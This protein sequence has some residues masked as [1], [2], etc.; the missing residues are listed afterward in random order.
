MHWFLTLT[1][2]RQ[3]I[4]TWRREYN[5]SRPHRA[6]GDRTPSEFAGQIA[7]QGDLTGSQTCRRADVTCGPPRPP[8]RRPG[9]TGSTRP[10]QQSH[11]KNLRK[12]HAY[13]PGEICR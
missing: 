4:E 11:E 7:V 3:R 2:A 9:E 8:G 1:E 6:L 5:E 12:P 10:G 13:S